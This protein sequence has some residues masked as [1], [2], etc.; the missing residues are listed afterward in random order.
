MI[1][2]LSFAKQHW[3]YIYNNYSINKEA[4]RV[5]EKRAQPVNNPSALFLHP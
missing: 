2:K 5:M 1:M 4:G 3:G